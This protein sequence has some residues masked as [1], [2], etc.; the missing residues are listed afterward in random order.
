MHAVRVALVRVQGAKFNDEKQKIILI[1]G[2]RVIWARKT[3]SKQAGQSQMIYKGT[4]DGGECL[5]ALAARCGAS[6]GV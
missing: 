2:T 1:G 5:G 4:N 3:M 6:Q